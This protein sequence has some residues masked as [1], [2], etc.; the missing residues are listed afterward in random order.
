MPVATHVL[1]LEEVM[2]NGQGKICSQIFVQYY[3]DPGNLAT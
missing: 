3:N 1:I 2:N